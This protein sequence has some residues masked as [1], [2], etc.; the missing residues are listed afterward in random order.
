MRPPAIA[1]SGRLGSRLAERAGLLLAGSADPSGGFF[2][3]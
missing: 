3:G 2:S 1:A